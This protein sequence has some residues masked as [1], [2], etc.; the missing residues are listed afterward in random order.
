MLL[1]TE[2]YK[3]EDNKTE[4]RA[5]TMRGFIATLLAIIW[6]KSIILRH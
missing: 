3:F 5:V 4:R 1:L 6:Y 2:K